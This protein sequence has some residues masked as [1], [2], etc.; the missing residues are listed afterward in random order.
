MNYL[1][2]APCLRGQVARYKGQAYGFVQRISCKAQLTMLSPES[3][4][5]M[6]I[7]VVLGVLLIAHCSF[8]KFLMSCLHVLLPVDHGASPCAM[9]ALACVHAQ[10]LQALGKPGPW[11]NPKTLSLR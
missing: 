8:P 3:Y 9:H 6:L 1:R 5:P 2:A 11:L 4:G 7:C 10:C